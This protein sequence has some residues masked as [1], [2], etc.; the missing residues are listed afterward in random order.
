LKINESAERTESA[1]ED[2]ISSTSIVCKKEKFKKFRYIRGS[3]A[4]KNLLKERENLRINRYKDSHIHL[5]SLKH[6][7]KVQ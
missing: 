7:Q 1:K 3:A 2:S 4:E 5:I 6:E